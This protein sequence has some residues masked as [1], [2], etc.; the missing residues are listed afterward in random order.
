MA[1][2]VRKAPSF[3]RY[4]FTAAIIKAGVTGAGLAVAALGAADFAIAVS[5]KEALDALQIDQFF[6]TFAASGAALGVV[7]QIVKMILSR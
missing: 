1:A 5:A 4:M 3:K 6:N 7:W 2:N